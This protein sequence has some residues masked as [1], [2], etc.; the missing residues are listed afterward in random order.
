[1]S[2]DHFDYLRVIDKG[3]H[4]HLLL[5]DWA[6]QR[7]DMPLLANQV[8]PF[9]GGKLEGGGGEAVFPAFVQPTTAVDATQGEDV[10][11]TWFGPED[12]E[13]LAAST[14]DGLASGFDHAGGGE[15]FGRPEGAILY[16]L[17]NETP[18]SSGQGGSRKRS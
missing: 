4:P 10:G 9:P 6:L 16:P 3:N 8:A 5:A 12:S 2:N 1:M 18:Q 13:L 17:Y 7:V 14:D 11:G 15:V